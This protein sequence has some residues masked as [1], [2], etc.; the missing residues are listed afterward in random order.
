MSREDRK[1]INNDS[2]GMCSRPI[3]ASV[4]NGF[5]YATADCQTTLVYN[6][7]DNSWSNC[8][9]MMHEERLGSSSCALGTQLF[10]IGGHS[11]D[12]MMF[13]AYSARNQ[14]KER[15]NS[16]EWLDTVKNP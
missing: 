13:M 11:I 8:L 3:C 1:L 10:V 15:T 9:P 16:V 6:L 4:I 5:V 12:S 2:V 7:K 14:L